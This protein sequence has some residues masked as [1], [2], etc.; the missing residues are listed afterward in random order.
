[1]LLL[2]FGSTYYIKKVKTLLLPLLEEI[3]VI[4][5]LKVG[6]LNFYLDCFSI[7]NW[8]QNDSSVFVNLLLSGLLIT[9]AEHRFKTSVGKTTLRI[10]RVKSILLDLPVTHLVVHGHGYVLLEV[11]QPLRDKLL[12]PQRQSDRREYKYHR[13]KRSSSTS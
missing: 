3:F 7:K 10:Q 9:L 4:K 12:N 6:Q 1:M 13:T 5:R 8:F 2:L 11:L